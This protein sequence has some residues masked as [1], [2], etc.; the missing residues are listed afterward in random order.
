MSYIL[1]AL[2]KAEA[3][4]ER[5]AIPGLTTDQS[6]NSVYMSLANHH[7]P[8]WLLLVPLV[9]LVLAWLVW[10]VRA[11]G[12]ISESTALPTSARLRLYRAR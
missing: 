7:K 10:S 8:R 3:E 9:L 2:K 1:E 4:R 12:T 6:S 11:P 5:G